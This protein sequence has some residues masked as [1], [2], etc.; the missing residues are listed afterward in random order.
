MCII[1]E[2]PVP[3][4][5]QFCGVY[6]TPL[7]S[8][9]FLVCVRCCSPRP[10][11]IGWPQAPPVPLT[12]FH[13]SLEGCRFLL[14]ISKMAQ[15]PFFTHTLHWYY[16]YCHGS[17]LNMDFLWNYFMLY[18]VHIHFVQVKLQAHVGRQRRR[19][20]H[21]KGCIKSRVIQIPI[22]VGD[23]YS[24]PVLQYIVYDSLL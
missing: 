3:S 7:T 18:T 13:W 23:V 2:A 17:W 14:T 6:L 10:A 8:G 15:V 4:D 20:R 22:C 9:G 19:G 16:Y 1:K 21:L 24:E 11:P 5:R 12:V